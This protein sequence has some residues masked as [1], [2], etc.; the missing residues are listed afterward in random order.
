MFRRRGIIVPGGFGERG[1]EG[2]IR[3]CNWARTK[4][5]PYLG[6]CLGLQVAVIEF[7][8]NVL[9]ISDAHTTE[10]N[11][12]TPNPL[13]INMPEISTTHL[14]GTMRLGSRTTKFVKEGVM[15]TFSPSFFFNWNEFV[16]LKFT[17]LLA[18]KLYGK[19][20]IAERH[21]HRYE[22]NT[23]YLKDLEAK[24]LIFVGHDDKAERMEI[25]E[26][27]G[28]NHPYFV[29]TQFHPEYTTRPLRPSP[30]FLGLVLASIGKLDDYIAGKTTFGYST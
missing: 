25:L 26:L 7:A 18:E 14:G 11:K 8:R 3:A 24:G 20:Q 4:K 17:A 21:R 16:L 23:A 19:D 10:I 28:Q 13:V 27:Q 22:V 15:S 12:D 29:A 5:I 2:K 30:P 9:N 1:F 6:I